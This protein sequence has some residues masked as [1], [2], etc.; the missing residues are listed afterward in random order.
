MKKYTPPNWPALRGTIHTLADLLAIP[1][2]PLRGGLEEMMS[3]SEVCPELRPPWFEGR[4]SRA[5]VIRCEPY[6]AAS[7]LE[8][9]RPD[10]CR[11][12]RLAVLVHEGTPCLLAMGD[13]R[14]GTDYTDRAILN[15]SAY[16]SAL[17]AQGVGRK[18]KRG[19]RHRSGKRP[20]GPVLASDCCPLPGAHLGNKLPPLQS[21]VVP[22]T[23]SALPFVEFGSGSLFWRRESFGWGE[24]VMP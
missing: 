8:P 3:T 21:D 12:W 1:R 24:E 18:V 10:L 17:L 19:E 7:P 14:C 11:F 22:L 6:N 9:Y 23:A 2:R 15:P 16:L 4:G 13:G 5:E 20:I